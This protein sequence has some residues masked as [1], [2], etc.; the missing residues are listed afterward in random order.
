[1]TCLLPP[2]GST[3]YAAAGASASLEAMLLGC[4]G[5]GSRY[6]A[7]LGLSKPDYT[8]YFQLAEQF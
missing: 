6:D 5:N 8:D 4:S 7:F 2:A 1:M 3:S